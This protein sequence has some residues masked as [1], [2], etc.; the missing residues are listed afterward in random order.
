MKTLKTT[1]LLLLTVILLGSCKS[2][3]EKKTWKE[4]HENEMKV[5]FSTLK[6]LAIPV[7][8]SLKVQDLSRKIK[9][10][11]ESIYEI[12]DGLAYEDQMFF[13]FAFFKDLNDILKTYQNN[14]K[15]LTVLQSTFNSVTEQEIQK[16]NDNCIYLLSLLED[17][18]NNISHN[19]S[20]N[21]LKGG[22]FDMKVLEEYLTSKKNQTQT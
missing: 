18:F 7:T 9:N 21:L 19:I 3:L 4:I 20:S 13:E 11:A 14:S 1:T 6:T 2:A 16:N 10:F 12:K 22:S 8:I 5:I 17:Q 15:N